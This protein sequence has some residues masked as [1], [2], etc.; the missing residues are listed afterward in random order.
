MGT[1]GVSEAEAWDL[2]LTDSQPAF[3]VRTT[4]LLANTQGS[5]PAGSENELSLGFLLRFLLL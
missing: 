4:S 2:R 5:M 1:V 3:V